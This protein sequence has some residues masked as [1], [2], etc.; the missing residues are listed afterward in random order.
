MIIVKEKNRLIV[1]LKRGQNVIASLEK[2]ATSEKSKS[3]TFTALGALDRVELAH[4]NVEKKKY[5]S[6]KF[7]AELELISFIGNIAWH[8]GKPIVHAHASLSNPKMKVI[9]GHFVE[10]RVS[11]TME[12][13]LNILSAR[14]E[15]SFDPETGL[16]LMKKNMG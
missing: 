14:I 2:L 10:G 12:I 16:K 13:S 8:K 15:K 9:G 1:R 4:Y 5:S 7:K 6:K 11:G 3:A